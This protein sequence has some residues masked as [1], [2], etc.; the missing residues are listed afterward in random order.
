MTRIH[1]IP[2]KN[3]RPKLETCVKCLSV[4]LVFRQVFQSSTFSTCTTSA[5]LVASSKPEHVATCGPFRMRWWLRW[6]P[7]CS[8]PYSGHVTAD[9]VDV[10]D[11]S[12][13]NSKKC[14]LYVYVFIYIY[15]YCLWCLLNKM[16]D[17]V[18]T[19]TFQVVTMHYPLLMG[20]A[21]ELHG[22]NPK[23]IPFEKSQKKVKI[24]VSLPS[25]QHV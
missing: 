18:C 9:T 1:P 8:A 12:L 17:D 13:R 23:K 10:I 7:R 5:H 6:R 2:E 4:P 15:T 3:L 22:K 21:T 19:F 25:Q 14:I 16:M 24:G 11:I 20:F